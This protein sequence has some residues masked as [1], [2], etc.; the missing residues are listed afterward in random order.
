MQ[1]NLVNTT[2]SSADGKLFRV[3]DVQDDTV[4]YTRNDTTYYCPMAAF[5]SRFF[6][7]ENYYDRG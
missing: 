3:V 2:W 5:K 1:K 7:T 4:W 6:I